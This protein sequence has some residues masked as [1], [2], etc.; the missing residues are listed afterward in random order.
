MEVRVICI[1]IL[2]PT[3]EEARL[4]IQ[5]ASLHADLIE[6]RLDY[7]IHREPTTLKSLLK[8]F[9]LPMIFTLRSK[10]QGGHYPYDEKTRLQEIKCLAACNPAYLDIEAD[11]PH[12]F[13]KQISQD[14]PGIK[15]IISY[16]HFKDIPVNLKDILDKLPVIKNGIYKIATHSFCTADALK[17]MHEAKNQQNIISISM[18]EDGQISRILAPV[19]GSPITY[20]SLD[21]KCKAAPGQLPAQQLREIYG[22]KALNPQTALYG[23]IGDPVAASISHLTHN[24]LMQALNL[25]AV[26]VK[27]R[28][29]PQELKVCLNLMKKLGFQGLSVT[30]PLKEKIISLLDQVDE[31]ALAIGAVN[32]LLLKDGQWIGYNT[33]GKGALESI[34][35][36]GAVKDKKI[37]LLGA[38]GAA[39]AIAFEAR[40]KGA[41][42]IILNR[43][44]QK[45]EQLADDFGGQAGSLEMMQACFQAGYDILINCTSHSFP[46]A[47]SNLSKEALVMDITSNPKDTAFLKGAIKRGCRIVY[48]YQMFIRQ[49]VKQFKLWFPEKIDEKDALEILEKKA[50][51]SLFVK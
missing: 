6:L 38:G 10:S 15:L 35:T 22:Y 5:Q 19:V 12:A 25:N 13:I 18:G 44:I 14:Q 31:E 41:A 49:A 33:D 32:T 48:G 50:L 47:P 26:Y 37:I 29:K 46:I 21:E 20:A 30:M 27:M 51:E 1:V 16:H 40:R 3:L 43:T 8:E 7:F 11:V 45:A 28:V 24:A 4:Q 34:E 42:L 17:Q 9:P 36:W 2:G 39:R 23:L